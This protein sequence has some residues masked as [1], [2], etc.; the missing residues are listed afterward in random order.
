MTFVADPFRAGSPW[1]A[2]LAPLAAARA[3]LV[4]AGLRQRFAAQVMRAAWPGDPA[5]WQSGA[6]IQREAGSDMSAGWHE[7]AWL[8]AHGWA[9]ALSPAFARCRP[10]SPDLDTLNDATQGDHA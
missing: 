5:L 2:D 6:C 10:L 8:E 1:F 9:D 3:R 7:M 4:L